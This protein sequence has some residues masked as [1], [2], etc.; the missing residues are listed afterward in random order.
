MKRIITYSLR[1]EES[2]SDGYYHTIADFSQRWVEAARVSVGE[3]VAGFQAFHVES[4]RL[5]RSFPECGFELLVLGVMLQEHGAQAG[6]MPSGSVRLLKKLIALQGRYPWTEKAIKAGRGWIVNL[7]GPI[8]NRQNQ[9]GQNGLRQT[10]LLLEWMRAL[11]YGGQVERLADWQSYFETLEPER[12]SEVIAR[13]LRLAQD[14]TEESQRMLGVYTRGVAKFL[15]EEA[16]RHAWQYDALFVARRPVEYHLGMLGTELLSRAYRERFLETQRK[17]V[18]LPPCMRGQPE[19]TCKALPTPLGDHC[20]DC[21]PGC[22]IR[23]VTK[24]GERKGFEVYMMPDE[25]RK[26]KSGSPQGKNTFGVVG[27]SCALTN[28]SG[29]WDLDKEGIPGQGLLLD[30]VGCSYHWDKHGI[31][32]EVNLHKLRELIGHKKT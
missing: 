19:G 30:F 5:A 17:V 18:I 4:G 27:V 2:D 20:M 21:T 12:A 6:H 22:P 13:C 14:F 11:D 8:G 3:D 7:A 32:T 1:K 9:P 23:A 26:F 31:P 10:Q 25:L 16:P 24:L 29:G 15:R 28:W